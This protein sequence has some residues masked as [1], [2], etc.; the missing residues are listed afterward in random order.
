[1]QLFVGIP[2]GFLPSEDTGNIFAFTEAAQGISFESMVPHQRA[3][4]KIVMAHP[5]GASLSSSVGAG[6]AI[7]ASNSGT[8]FIRLKPRSERAMHVDQIIQ[9]LRP[10]LAQVPGIRVCLHNLPPIRIGGRLTRSQY[11]YTLQSPGT[12]EL[13]RYAPLLQSR[14][15]ELPQLQD[16]ASDLQHTNPQL[17]INITPVFFLCMESLRQLLRRTFVR[18]AAVRADSLS[19]EVAGVPETTVVS[20]APPDR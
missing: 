19:G 10:Q 20:G 9:E 8:L 1:M 5:G 6:G 14:I 15:E 13:Y 7:G 2:K 12:D 4:A 11:Q 18:T 3:V 17:N 16:V